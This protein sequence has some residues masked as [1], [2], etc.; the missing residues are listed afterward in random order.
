MEAWEKESD[1]RAAIEADPEIGRVLKPEQ[2]AQSFSLDRQ[3]RNVDKIFKRVFDD[4]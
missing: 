4:R 1:F 2:I 3:L